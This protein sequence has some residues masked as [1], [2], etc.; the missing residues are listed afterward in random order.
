MTKEQKD[1]SLRKYRETHREKL[2]DKQRA[3]YEANHEKLIERN[4]TYR[5][6]N[7]EKIKENLREWRLANPDKVKKR[8]KERYAVNPEKSKERCK[9]WCAANQDRVRETM[10]AYRTANPEKVRV[11][12]R[13]CDLKRIYGI[14]LGEYNSMSLAQGGACAIC[15][16][17]ERTRRALAVD[18]NHS[19]GKVRGLLCWPC[20]AAL[21]LFMDDKDLLSTAI[22]Y[23]TER[24]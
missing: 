6:A 14:T 7:P 20:N 8:A 4:K 9:A 10:K 21:G 18:H 12:Q 2:R 5:A 15:G 23:L 1:E 19:T 24:G 16:K 3:Y 11:W 17:P 22:S 13:S